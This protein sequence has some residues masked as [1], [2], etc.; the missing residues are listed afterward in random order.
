[1]DSELRQQFAER[2]SP[3]KYDHLVSAVNDPYYWKAEFRICETPV[4]LTDEW[5]AL[6]VAAGER[7]LDQIQTPEFEAHSKGAIPPGEEVP[8]TKPHPEF[9]QIDFAIAEEDGKLVPKLIELQGFASM[10]CYQVALDRG[11]WQMGLVPEGVSQYFNGLEDATFLNSL[12]SLVVG[13]VPAENVVLLEI[14]PERQRTRVDFACTEAMIGVKPVCLT[15][16]RRDGRTLYYERDGRKVEIR[17]I[18]NRV[19]FDELG[20]LDLDLQFH[21]TDEVDV[22]WVAHPNW[23]HKLS[24]HTLPFLSGPA[25]PECRFLSDV[26]SLP[27]DL[28]N[29]VLKPL[30]SFAGAGV[31][32]DVTKEA[33]E[34]VSQPENYLLQQKVKYAE[35]LE[36]PTGRS[37]G[38]VR[39][40]YLWGEKPVLAS[41]L[42]RISRGSLS[43]VSKN[44]GESWIG[45][46]TGYHRTL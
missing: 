3:E 45:A 27:D 16:L 12:K 39:L 13:D 14:Q 37:K 41:T 33:I 36:T 10:F 11:Y 34:A 23:F 17:R 8:N 46:T 42:V 32:V 29:Y 24:K 31:I 7:I 28:S 25:V 35:F 19:I 1:M 40:M 44:T 15:Q 43:S 30:Y 21:P 18:Y 6:A 22:D 2:W 20:Q 9:V 5:T 26:H 38:E 4:F